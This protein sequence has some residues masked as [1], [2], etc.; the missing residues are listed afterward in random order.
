MRHAQHGARQHDGA[1]I[2]IGP[3]MNP[4]GSDGATPHDTHLHGN[5][6]LVDDEP[7][8]LEIGAATLRLRG[9][10]VRTAQSAAEAIEA[11]H[12][13]DFDVVLLDVHLGGTDGID[14]CTRLLS[15]WPTLVVVVVTGDT[16]SVSALAAMRAGAFDY[17]TKPVRGDDLVLATERALRHHLKVDK[18]A[19]S[20]GRFSGAQGSDA[21][22]GNSAGVRHVLDVIARIA[23]TSANVLVTGE[24]GTGKELVARAIHLHSHRAKGPFIALNCAALPHEL[25]ESELFGHVR[26]AFTDAKTS[27]KGLFLEASG[28]TLFLDE[29]GEMPLATQVKLLRSLQERTVRPVGG[30]AEVP[31]DARLI[32]ATNRDLAVD[33]A[34]KHFREDLY[35]RINVVTIAVPP[36]RQRRDDIPLLAESF[37][38]RFAALQGKKVPVISAAAMERLVARSWP[39]NVRELEN[40]IERAVSMSQSDVLGAD[41]FTGDHAPPIEESA[42]VVA[43]VPPLTPETLVTADVQE[44]LYV[45]YVLD[46]VGGNK[47]RAAEVL[48]YDRRTL[49]R[50][51]KRASVG[52]RSVPEAPPRGPTL[53]APIAR[54]KL[55][56]PSGRRVLVVDGDLEAR[57]LLEAALEAR[58]HRVIAVSSM[59]EALTHPSVDVVVTELALRDG[60]GPEIAFRF[61]PTP[62]IAL[63]TRRPLTQDPFSSWLP[64]PSPVAAVL[65]AIERAASG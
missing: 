56:A 49:H 33:V 8:I 60:G 62:V 6:L 20:E 47:S 45:Q 22:L 1:V 3:P 24:S 46:R 26:G 13:T 5:V 42:V 30:T 52:E 55:V 37:L 57:D 11:A 44:R 16:S 34:A 38:R 27:R 61:R 36:L 31:F 12:K 50:K 9:H 41:A 21:I 48:G 32:A 17:L 39:G 65:A 19:P 28:G 23:S 54:A 18:P 63:S 53:A 14:L 35:Y 15:Q 2:A 64:K 40:A 25:L 59:R 43:S 7:D 4:S 58:G 51:L 10:T 29:I